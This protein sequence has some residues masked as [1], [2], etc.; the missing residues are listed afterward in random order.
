MG[1]SGDSH[2]ILLFH[3]EALYSKASV[4]DALDRTA[5][6]SPGSKPGVLLFYYKAL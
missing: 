4:T 6:S 2:S 1:D 3:R 5:Q